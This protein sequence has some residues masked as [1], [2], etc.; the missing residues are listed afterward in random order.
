MNKR[1]RRIFR[2]G[3]TARDKSRYSVMAI[4]YF[5]Y[6]I[7]LAWYGDF[8]YFGVPKFRNGRLNMLQNAARTALL[9]L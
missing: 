6:I 4:D 1:V 9:I 5:E 7:S 8:G 3:K 2:L